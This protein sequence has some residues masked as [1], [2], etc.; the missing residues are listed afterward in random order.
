MVGINPKQKTTH[1]IHICRSEGSTSYKS[2][3]RLRGNR[4]NWKDKV[5]PQRNDTDPTHSIWLIGILSVKLCNLS[6]L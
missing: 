6:M 3:L 2:I 1:Q 5:R 4:E